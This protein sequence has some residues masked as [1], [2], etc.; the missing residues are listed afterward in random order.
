MNTPANTP[1]LH[2]IPPRTSCALSQ[3]ILLPRSR[4]LCFSEFDR[5]PSPPLQNQILCEP[6]GSIS[7]HS[8][9][10]P[11]PF[12][13]A[14]PTAWDGHRRPFLRREADARR[15]G[16][17]SRTQRPEVLQDSGVV[18]VLLHGHDRRCIRWSRAERDAGRRPGVASPSAEA[19]CQRPPLPLCHIENGVGSWTRRGPGDGPEL[20]SFGDSRCDT[21]GRCFVHPRNFGRSHAQHLLEHVA[22]VLGEDRGR[23]IDGDRRFRQLPR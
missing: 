22:V 4:R 3:G 9:G 17:D 16:P 13:S 10:R 14:Y 15:P 23:T 12:W 19:A 7:T 20:S 21:R 6:A 11:T 18:A 5:S 2:P 1:H 8:D